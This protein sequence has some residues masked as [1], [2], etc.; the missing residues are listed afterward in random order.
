MNTL[1]WFLQLSEMNVHCLEI[2]AD[3][4]PFKKISQVNHRRQEAEKS[5]SAP[6]T[7]QRWTVFVRHDGGSMTSPQARATVSSVAAALIHNHGRSTR[8][9]CRRAAVEYSLR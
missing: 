2:G 9:L 7:E 1:S 5:T 8:L 4:I 6:R 3:S